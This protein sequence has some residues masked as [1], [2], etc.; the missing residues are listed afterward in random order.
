[1]KFIIIL[2]VGFM[3]YAVQSKVIATYRYTK[4][5]K[6]VT[7]QVT[8]KEAKLAYTAVKRETFQ[9]PS[10]KQFFNDFLRFKM[11]V[12]VAYHE[13]ALVKGPQINNM[14]VSLPL[15]VSFEQDLYTALAELKLQKQLKVL[16]EKSAKLPSKTLKS[17]YAKD[18]EF[19]YNYI[20][21]NHPLNPTSGQ[22]NEAKTRAQKVYRQ[23][24]SSKKP[25]GELVVLHS[26]DKVLGALELNRSRAVILP[27]VYSQLKKMKPG[28]I[29]KPLRVPTG[30][31]I[32]KLIRRVPFKEANVQSI[33]LDY[34]N[35]ERT[36]ISL[37]YF[38]GL[39]KL[40]T[41]KMV[42]EKLI[43]SL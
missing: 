5:P 1:M 13:P 23:V 10:K 35:E 11:A 25:F 18:P 37:K 32:I 9:P 21:V 38:N 28:Q 29:S 34:F 7:K 8:L 2:S 24:V 36:R 14:I 20:A 40:F 22:I 15:R 27:V 31:N 41:V 3:S 39:K 30:Y 26:D 4:A 17:L 33:R 43:Q 6:A 12:E 42:N 16:G 19:S